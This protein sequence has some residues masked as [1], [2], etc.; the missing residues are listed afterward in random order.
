[1]TENNSSE[2][3]IN[4][5]TVR[6]K[7]KSVNS[8]SS[9]DLSEKDEEYRSL[10]STA[11]YELNRSYPDLYLKSN[12][13]V[14]EL[15]S[16]ICQLEEKLIIAETE[17]ENLLLENSSQ[18]KI[19]NNYKLKIDK[20]THICTNTSSKK[21]EAKIKRKSLR[22]TK[23]DFKNT[24][25]SP[26][27]Q[28]GID[29]MPL[30]DTI[31]GPN[32]M[33]DGLPQQATLEGTTR[34][35]ATGSS[36]QRDIIVNKTRSNKLCLISD[37]NVNAILGIAENTFPNDK[38]C[39]YC[40]PKA[41]IM[42][43]LETLDKKL[44]NYTL[45]DHCIIFIGETDFL[46]SKNYAELVNYIKFRLEKILH[47]NIIL[48]CP[49]FKL[50]SNTSLFNTRIESFNRLLL[51]SN[52]IFNF[53]YTFDTNKQLEYSYGMFSKLTGKVNNAAIKNVFMN[54]KNYLEL[55]KPSDHEYTCR[56]NNCNMT[57]TYED[58]VKCRVKPGTIPYYFSKMNTEQLSSK[59][60]SNVSTGFN[61]TDLFRE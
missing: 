10:T 46:V 27:Q 29:K 22:R 57:H 23:L 24:Q 31:I 25:Q 34:L 47:T 14:E 15:R 50:K 44:V 7:C 32:L 20:L 42:K 16:R 37:N 13:D 3:H 1:M 41:G 38:I 28:T 12:D 45:N 33:Y 56:Y 58:S 49:T 26:I 51:Q 8:H 35:D 48:C 19:I 55:F 18:A 54:L 39:H 61:D 17:I 6:N 21:S 60:V 59:V 2:I 43:L 52:Q 4:N 9:F 5:V 30:E 40:M 53:T 36:T 11:S